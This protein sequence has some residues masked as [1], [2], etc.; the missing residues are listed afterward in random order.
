MLSGECS[1]GAFVPQLRALAM[2]ELC[3]TRS[4]ESP[5]KGEHLKNQKQLDQP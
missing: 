1:I 2:E 4:G 5:H 3:H